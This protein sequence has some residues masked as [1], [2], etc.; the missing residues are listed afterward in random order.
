ME[1][2]YT[3]PR[4]KKKEHSSRYCRE[5]KK[6]KKNRFRMPLHILEQPHQKLQNYAK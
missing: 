2:C 6:K 1:L 5:K 4:G 3:L